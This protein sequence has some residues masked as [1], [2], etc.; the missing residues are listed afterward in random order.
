MRRVVDARVNVK[1][2]GQALTARFLIE[3]SKKL[4]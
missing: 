3:S 2:E 1:F 4:R